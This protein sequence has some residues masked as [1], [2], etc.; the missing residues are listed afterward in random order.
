MRAWYA[1]LAEWQRWCL[2][3]LCIPLI[4]VVGILAMPTIPF[5]LLIGT[6]RDGLDRIFN[7]P[8]PP[9]GKGRS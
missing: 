1:S 6:A 8:E 4:P 5:F 3:V 9:C 7:A 2:S